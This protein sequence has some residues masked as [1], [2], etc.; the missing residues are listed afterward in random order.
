MA[1][2]AVVVKSY[3]LP[4]YVG[5]STLC[6]AVSCSGNT[7]ETVEAAQEAVLAGARVIALS[8]GGELAE[9]AEANGSPHIRVPDFVMPRAAIGALAV[10]LLVLLERVG[11]FPGATEWVGAAVTQLKRR[12]DQLVRDDNAMERLARS[13]GGSIPLIYGGNAIGHVAAMRWK[14]QVNENSKVPAFF[15]TV[16]EACHN[17][18]C[19]W[20]QH[21]DMTRQVLSYVELRHEHEHPQVSRRFDLMRDD[22]AEVVREVHQVRAEGD[23]ALAQL[24]DLVIQGDFCSLHLAFQAGI[25][26]GPIPALDALKQALA[27]P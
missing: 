8:S 26:P 20:G 21:G 9:L 25:D 16:P 17:E 2:P 5:P 6:F 22:I 10:P 13:L 4:S 11:L 3:T 18:I 12:R 19:G 15:N 27:S 1:V 23:G 24:L 7:E 14:T